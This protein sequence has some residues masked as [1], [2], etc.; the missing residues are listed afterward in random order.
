MTEIVSMC[1]GARQR[2]QEQYCPLCY[3]DAAWVDIHY[4]FA[5]RNEPAQYSNAPSQKE[6]TAWVRRI[7]F[8]RI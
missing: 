1:C 6:L 4:Y 7:A 2:D 5:N 8:G 3:D